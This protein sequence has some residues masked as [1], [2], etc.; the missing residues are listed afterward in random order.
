MV[1]HNLNLK[2]ITLL[3][4]KDDSPLLINPNA[5]EALPVAFK[6]LETIAWWNAQILELVCV[7]QAQKFSARRA[8]ELGGE[9][10]RISGLAIFIQI[11]RKFVAKAAYHFISIR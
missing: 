4:T 8:V 1:I 3:P 6:Q 9:R 2:G 10:S 11:L 5:M 7:P